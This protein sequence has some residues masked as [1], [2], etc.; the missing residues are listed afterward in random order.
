[1]ALTQSHRKSFYRGPYESLHAPLP[2]P[3]EVTLTAVAEV[4]RLPAYLAGRIAK[5]TCYITTTVVATDTPA[6][7]RV[8]RVAGGKTAELAR[9]NIA[10]GSTAGS[11]IETAPATG[12]GNPRAVAFTSDESPGRVE[13]SAWNPTDDYILIDVEQA[14]TGNGAAGA[15]YVILTIKGNNN[16]DNEPTLA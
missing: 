1:M 13:Y 3:K 7:V 4:F 9:V 14:A 10:D 8:Q 5:V 6:I 11:L 12:V 16:E 2:I 15:C